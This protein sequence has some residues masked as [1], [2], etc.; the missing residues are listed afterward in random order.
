MDVVA[1]LVKIEKQQYTD[2]DAGKDQMK[3]KINKNLLSQKD[4]KIH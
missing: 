4:T 3:L 1:Y 2:L